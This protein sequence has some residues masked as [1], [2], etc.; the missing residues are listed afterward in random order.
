MGRLPP[1]VAY[2]ASAALHL[3]A[4]AALARLPPLPALGDDVSVEVIDVAPPAPQPPAP[5]PE[6][7]AVA[8]E[9]EL[10]PAPR[11]PARRVEVPRDAPRVARPDPAP[12]PPNAEPPEDAPR[13]APVRVGVAMSATTEGGSFPAPSGNTL[14]GELPRTAP[15]PDAQAYRSERYVPPAQVTVLPRPITCEIPQAEYPEAARRAGVEGRVVLTLVVDEAGRVA[16]AKVL[17][18]PGHGLGEAAVAGVKRHCRFEPA[19]KGEERVATR[20]RYTVRYELP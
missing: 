17:E 3:A 13:R 19:R 18:A 2:A 9:P 14:Y 5:A 8:P 6:P 4:L 11:R 10:A 16:E 12:P 15:E 7:A 1:P 20:L